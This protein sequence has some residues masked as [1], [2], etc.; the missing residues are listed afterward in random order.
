M[1]LLD[2]LATA[3]RFR[4]SSRVREGAWASPDAMEVGVVFAGLIVP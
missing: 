1:G 2:D 3:I 4:L